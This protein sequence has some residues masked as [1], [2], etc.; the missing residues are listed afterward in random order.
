[1]K[2]TIFATVFAVA[3]AAV[4]AQLDISKVPSC[5]VKCALGSIAETTCATTDF[6]CICKDS[7]FIESLTPCISQG[8]GS[9]DQKTMIDLATALCTTYGVTIPSD[10]LSPT[11]GT[12]T[13]GTITSTPSGPATATSDAASTSTN[14]AARMAGSGFVAAAMGAALFVL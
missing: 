14:G 8:C 13:N 4:S 2:A 3:I 6:G 11:N 10:I 1:M 7:K 5:A 9:S 12:T